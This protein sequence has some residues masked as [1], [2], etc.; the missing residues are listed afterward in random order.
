MNQLMT[1]REV[2]NYLRIKERKIYDLVRAKRIPCTRVTGKWLFPKHLIDLWVAQGTEFPELA[3]AALTPAPPV[4]VGSH[5]PLLEWSLRESGCQLAM[6]SGGSLDGLDRLA[7]GEAMMCGLHVLDADTGDYNE[8]VARQACAGLDVVLIE[9]AWRRQGLVLAPGNPKKIE[10]VTD[11]KTKKARVVAR[12]REA[13]SQILLQYLL[14]TAGLDAGDLDVL[15]QPARSETDL[16]LA[17]LEGKADA[18]VAIATV[19]RQYRLDFLPL[20][21]ERYDLLMRRRDYFEPP[22]QK[23]FAFTRSDAFQ[24]RA[25]DMEG[26]DVSALGRVVYNAP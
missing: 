2:A 5:D 12:Q 21:R 4:V 10:S 26:Y 16:G 25:R 6:M 19:A 8:P 24:A 1:T 13:G 18:G 22:V 14:T 20:H 23:L 11:L 3:K 17:V 15:A 9:W 7:A